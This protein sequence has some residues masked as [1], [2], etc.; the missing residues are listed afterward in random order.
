MTVNDIYS[1]LNSKFPITDARDFDNVGILVGDPNATV[2]KALIS[3]DCTLDTVNFARKNGCNL[4]ITHH[5]V[6]FDPLKNILDGTIVYEL[7]ANNLSVISMHTNLDVGVGGVNDCLCKAIG[8]TKMCPVTASDGY[9]LK[10]GKV[11]E[12]SA[13]DLAH[14]IKN[15]LGGSIKFVDGEKPIEKILVCSGSGGDYIETAIENGFD[16]LVTAD[17]KHHQFLL[18][19]D[20]GISLFDAGH[21]NTE[22]VIV[23]PLKA[24]LSSEFQSL[25]FITH[26]PNNILSV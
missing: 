5:P 6:I 13:E 17:V 8:I 18:A 19:L 26:H 2:S 16:A 11:D 10:G 1:F 12:I 3:L 24:L 4:I 15:A 21:F 25:E 22:D 7:V 20:N 14:D 23:D 9:L